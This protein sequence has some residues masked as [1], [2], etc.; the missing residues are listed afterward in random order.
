MAKVSVD[1]EACI[2]CGV[3][4][5]MCPDFFE[6]NGEGKSQIV[7]KYRVSGNPV[8]GE[9]PPELLD[10]IKGAAESCSVQAITVEE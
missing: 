6:D 5:T 7:E 3:C 9:A 8:E 10:D 4:W 2:G 1:Q